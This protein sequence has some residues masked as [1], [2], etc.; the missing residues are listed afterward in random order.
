MRACAAVYE[1]VCSHEC[2]GVHWHVCARC[3]AISEGVILV[4]SREVVTT[5]VFYNAAY[6]VLNVMY[7]VL[8]RVCTGPSECCLSRRS[9]TRT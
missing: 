2:A 6:I 8:T 4:D 7:I 9:T 1:G 5:P 3:A